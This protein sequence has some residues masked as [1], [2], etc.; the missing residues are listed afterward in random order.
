MALFKKLKEKI[1]KDFCFLE[2]FW[3]F[4]ASLVLGMFF[5]TPLTS[6]YFELLISSFVI[7][8]GF[9]LFWRYFKQRA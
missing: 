9:V 4:I 8:L 2:K 5:G 6:F 1:Q 3:I 7:W